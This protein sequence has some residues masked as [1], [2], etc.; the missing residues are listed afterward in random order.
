MVPVQSP[1]HRQGQHFEYQGEQERPRTEHVRECGECHEHYLHESKQGRYGDAARRFC[2][3][4][5]RAEFSCS[6]RS[7]PDGACATVA[8]TGAGSDAAFDCFASSCSAGSGLFRAPEIDQPAGPADCCQAGSHASCGAGK[9]NSSAQADS[10]AD[11]HRL[12]GAPWKSDAAGKRTAGSEAGSTCKRHTGWTAATW[13]ASSG[14][15]SSGKASPTERRAA[16]PK[17]WPASSGKSGRT[18]ASN[19]STARTTG[20]KAKSTEQA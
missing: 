10:W 8:T 13:A 18:A 20:G 4:S 11:G 15:A 12:A 7:S 1:L 2:F 17:P 5:R 6:R 3:R 19:S 14:T 9:A 16:G